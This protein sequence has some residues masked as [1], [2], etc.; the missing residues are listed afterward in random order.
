MFHVLFLVW[1]T[2]VEK[3]KVLITLCQW[4]TIPF[5]HNCFNDF[6]KIVIKNTQRNNKQYAWEFF[7]FLP[8]KF[9]N[10]INN[11]YN[12]KTPKYAH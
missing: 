2:F 1:L 3:I 8:Y 9:I 10:Y 11:C 6:L 5:T 7:N 12:H 4:L